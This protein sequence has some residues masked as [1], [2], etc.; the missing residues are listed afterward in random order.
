MNDL[1][2]MRRAIRL[3]RQGEGAVEPNPMVGA[4]VVS[5]KGEIVGEGWHQRYGEAHAEI[6]ALTQ[7]KEAAEGGTLYVTLEPCCHFGK[8]P[9]CTDAVLRSGVRRVVVAIRDPYPKV[10]GG[11][12]RILEKAGLDLTVGVAE[13]EV[14]SLMAPYL[15]LLSTGR[16]WVI[17]KWAMSI[18]GRT[19]SRT[20]HSRWI[21][22]E[23]SRQKGHELRGKVDAVIVG[24]GT[25][26]ADDPLLTAR[27]PGPRTPARVV[28]S[29]S[30]MLPAE[31]QLTRTIDAAPVVV[32]THKGEG[33]DRLKSW[34]KAGAEIVAL[35]T[36]GHAFLLDALADMGRR[37]WTNVLLEGGA[38][39]LGAFRDAGAIDE[40]WAFIAGK[41][42]GGQAAYAPVAGIGVEKVTDAPTL[43]EVVV[44]SCG[45]DVLI[46]G[47]VQRSDPKLS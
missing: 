18:D 19:A 25:V 17:A 10:A 36:T 31:C 27:P 29:P 47:R 6:N 46:R 45:E 7:A 9:P 26:V 34:K 23:H 35:E 2:L 28:F 12:L 11:G 13:D 5:A 24:R 30:G 43:S 1:E 38:Q 33:V 3:A 41:I 14:R 22:N 15:H 42:I 44:E 16:P 40:V 39:L 32:F 21:S 37:R 8:T 20:G 4:V